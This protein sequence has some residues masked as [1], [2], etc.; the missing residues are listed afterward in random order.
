MG[1]G[2][3]EEDEGEVE[4]ERYQGVCCALAVGAVSCPGESLRQAQSRP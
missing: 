4:R 1:E 3:E 2:G